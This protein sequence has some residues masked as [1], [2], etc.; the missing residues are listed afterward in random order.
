MEKY[1]QCTLEKTTS[2]GIARNVCY[3]PFNPKF[4]VGV[5]IRFKENRG[6]VWN[7]GW[8]IVSIGQP[9]EITSYEEKRY[10]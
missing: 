7:V 8:K 4:K 5:V 1:Q 9:V 2:E 10:K 3:L 6:S